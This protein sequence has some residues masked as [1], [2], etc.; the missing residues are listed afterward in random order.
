MRGHFRLSA[1]QL[2]VAPVT[3]GVLM[4]WK[5]PR[6]ADIALAPC[7]PTIAVLAFIFVSGGIVAASAAAIATHFASLAMAFVL[8]VAVFAIRN[9]TTPKMLRYP[10]SISLDGEHRSRHAKRRP[11]RVAGAAHF[12][13]I[14]ACCRGRSFQRRDAKHH[15]GLAAAWWKRRPPAA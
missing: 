5:L 14:S 7:G 3:L 11:G 8:H 2:T 15:R 6:M 12:P 4:R 13:A 10:E 1:L 9:P